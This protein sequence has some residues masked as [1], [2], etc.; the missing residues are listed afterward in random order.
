MDHQLD[1][2]KQQNAKLKS[3]IEKLR[4]EGINSKSKT[5]EFKAVMKKKEYETEEMN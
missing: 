2:K 5:N 3:E 1:Q 4:A